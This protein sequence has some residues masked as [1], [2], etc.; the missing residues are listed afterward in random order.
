MLI[1]QISIIGHD[2]VRC[3]AFYMI[4]SALNKTVSYNRIKADN[5]RDVQNYRDM[6]IGCFFPVAQRAPEMCTVI[7]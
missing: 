5:Y 3:V 4:M 6:E 1:A 7:F 2:A